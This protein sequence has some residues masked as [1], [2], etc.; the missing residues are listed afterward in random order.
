MSKTPARVAAKQ[1]YLPDGDGMPARIV[2][3]ALVLAVLVL[4]ARIA[5]VW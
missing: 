1:R 3:T 4:V 5:A 2:C